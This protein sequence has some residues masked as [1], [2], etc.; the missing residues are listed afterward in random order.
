MYVTALI[1]AIVFGT[2]GI[3]CRIISMVRIFSG[4][5]FVCDFQASEVLIILK[6]LNPSSKLEN[7]W[8]TEMTWNWAANPHEV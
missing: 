5:D 4:D 8:T 2:I 1:M 3:R 7:P 6:P